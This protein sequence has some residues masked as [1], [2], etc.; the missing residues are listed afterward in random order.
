ML[1]VFILLSC[2]LV[3]AGAQIRYR[4]CGNLKGIGDSL[5]ELLLAASYNSDLG[6]RTGE[7]VLG[8]NAKLVDRSARRLQTLHYKVCLLYRT[9]TV[10]PC[11]VLHAQHSFDC[12]VYFADPNNPSMMDKMRE[13]VK[14][15]GLF[16]TK[17]EQLP[18]W[19]QFGCNCRTE[20]QKVLEMACFFKTQPPVLNWFSK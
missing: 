18:A 20:N 10:M 1:F 4:R 7:K 2:L 8:D 16:L 13:A 3:N 5:L 19:V 9:S 12:N 11:A 15:Y 14:G 6:S 17:I